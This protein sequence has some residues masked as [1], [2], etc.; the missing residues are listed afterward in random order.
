MIY[1]T[2]EAFRQ[3]LEQRIRQQTSRTEFDPQERQSEI[4]RLRKY[5][6]FEAFL[7]RVENTNHNLILK[8][9][10]AMTLRLNSNCAE[11]SRARPT[12]DLDFVARRVDTTPQDPVA[13]LVE[14]LD[15][16]AAVTKPDFFSFMVL[17]A[18]LKDLVGSGEGAWRFRVDASIGERIFEKFHV[19]ISVGDVWPTAPEKHHLNSFLNF[20]GVEQ[21][22][23]LTISAEQH[24]AEK[25]HAL[26]LDRGDVVNSRVK[27]L[28]DLVLFIKGGIDESRVRLACLDV[29]AER[30]THAIPAEI[31]EQIPKFWGPKFDAMA[32]EIDLQ[33]SYEEAVSL[34]RNFHAE[35]F[36]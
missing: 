5:T 31:A 24:F 30:G 1:N 2:P 3:S 15:D 26:T 8:G 22:E 34:L 6:A 35:V 23:V 17:A 9:A 11:I 29:F 19:D 10:F 28:V 4:A 13:F 16:I 21:G 25:L 33:I 18:P 12:R 7:S 20:A 14:V 27:D 36:P 32:K